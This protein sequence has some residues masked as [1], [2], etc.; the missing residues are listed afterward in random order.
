[1]PQRGRDFVLVHG[2]GHGGWA[3][4]RVRDILTAAGH[5][6]F[7]PTLTGLG[8]RCHLLSKEVVLDTHIMDVANLFEW[9]DI[10]DAILV[11]HSYGGW[12]ISGAAERVES[13]LAAIAFVDAFLPRDGQRGYDLTT[14]VQQAAIDEA[15]AS[16]DVARPGPTGAG[17]KIQSPADI[18]WVNARI[19]PQPLGVSLQPVKLTGARERVKRKLYV[20]TPEF[21]QPVFDQAYESCKADP[22]WQT[23]VMHG[24]GHDPMIDK[25]MELS[26]ALIG[27]TG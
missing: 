2:A 18:A 27:L 19:T 8:D 5:R 10:S 16:G 7:T 3:W 12:V 15:V 4:S 11:G 13:R 20:R 25:P 24:C 21:P 22:G 1:M 9:E 14:P 23:L 6:V 26:E 17:L